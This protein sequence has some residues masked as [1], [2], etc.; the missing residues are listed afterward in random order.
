[1][2]FYGETPGINLGIL[3]IAYTVFTLFVTPEKNKTQTFYIL[4]VTS[5]VSSI[6]FAWYRD[7]PSFLAIGTS[8]LFLGLKSKTRKLKTLFIVPVFV[9]NFLLFSAGFSGLKDGF[10]NSILQEC[11][12]KRLLLF[13]F[14]PFL[15]R[16]SFV[17]IRMGVI[18]L[19]LFLTILNL[20][21]TFLSFSGWLF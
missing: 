6:A 8:L 15:S 4:L 18:I 3:G 14:L 10:L 12:R 1:V 19:P 5:F 20:I 21:S 11:C 16:C 7:F 9:T 2:L 13:L 17:F